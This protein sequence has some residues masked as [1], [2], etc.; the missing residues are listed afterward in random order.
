[1]N[2][3]RDARLTSYTTGDAVTSL[4]YASAINVILTRS[5]G[6]A[7]S[8]HY[9]GIGITLFIFIDWLGR[10]GIPFSFPL[11]ED[12]AKRRRPWVM[13]SKATLEIV[14]VYFLVA[15]AI[16][17]FFDTS[18]LGGLENIV[19]PRTAFAAFLGISFGWNILMLYVMTNLRFIELTVA[20]IA[21]CVF[22]LPGA[23]TYTKGFK[24]R[25]STS[26]SLW[27]CFLEGLGRTSAQ[28]VG[29]HITWVNPLASITLFVGINSFFLSQYSGGWLGSLWMFRIVILFFLMFLPTLLY[30]IGTAIAERTTEAAFVVR[31]IRVLSAILALALLLIFYMT[32]DGGSIIYVMIVQ[33]AAFGIF[34]QFAT[35]PKSSSDDQKTETP[36]AE[37]P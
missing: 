23:D 28:L 22:D 20:S 19:N 36:I 16:K 10:I 15:A 17:L 33:H 2:N 27:T 31:L 26:A 21:G 35:H 4:M 14:G 32:F 9:W 8:Y 12:Q 29:H 5:V 30:F 34:L 3:N 11:L 1:M 18:Y 7:D 13:L 6:I 24:D 37:N 25:F